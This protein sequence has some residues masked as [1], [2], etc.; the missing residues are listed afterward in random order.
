VVAFF[1]NIKIFCAFGIDYILTSNNQ[2]VSKLGTYTI[3]QI[4]KKKGQE[5]EQDT[6]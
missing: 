3:K 2:S 1:I 5:Q 6:N 4:N